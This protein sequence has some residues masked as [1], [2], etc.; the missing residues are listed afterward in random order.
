MNKQISVWIVIVYILATFLLP[1]AL[2][3]LPMAN[4]SENIDLFRGKGNIIF[5]LAIVYVWK[6]S[7]LRLRW[8]IHNAAS[9]KSLKNWRI[10]KHYSH[11]SVWS[12]V[13]G[14]LHMSTPK[15]LIYQRFLYVPLGS[16]RFRVLQGTLESFRVSYKSLCIVDTSTH[17]C[18]HY[19]TLP[20]T[21]ATFT[22]HPLQPT[23]SF[24]YVSTTILCL[25]LLSTT[26]QH[27]SL[28][29]TMAQFHPLPSPTAH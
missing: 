6:V 7:I 27:L 26:L 3:R 21:S 28:P 25:P 11:T 17:I 18:T 8:A 10:A 24:F 19:C 12:I 23:T 13:I 20:H 4:D 22:Y 2:A 16:F 15:L 5:F 9:C 1:K 14:D 29:S